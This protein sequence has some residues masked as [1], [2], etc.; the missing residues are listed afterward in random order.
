MSVI[1]HTPFPALAFR[2]YNLAGNMNGVV[3]VQGTFN[4]VDGGPMETAPDQLPL[5]MTDEFEGDPFA[6][7]M[8]AQTALVPFKPS[9]D[10]TFIG[11]TFAPGGKALRSWCCAI[12]VGSV[13]KKLRV[14]GPRDWVPLIVRRKKGLLQKEIVEEIAGWKLTEPEPVAEVPIDWTLAACD[15]AQNL[16]ANPE[17]APNGLNPLGIG[18]ISG[19]PGAKDARFAAPQIE[20]PDRPLK[21]PDQKLAPEGFGYISPWWKTR[22]Q[23]AGT[24]DD[25]WLKNR[26][27]LL[28]QDFDFRFWQSAHPDLISAK[29]FRGD[30]AYRLENLVYGHPDLRGHLPGIAMRMRLP[31]GDGFGLADFVLDG[32][33]FDLRAGKAHAVLTWRTG[34]PWP[35]GQ[36]TPE[37]AA[38]S[39][40]AEVA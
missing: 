22:L 13:S 34:F 23:Y 35:D 20:N 1:N 21:A 14:T 30:E 27:P 38:Y 15:L 33:H 40:L 26:H 37:I 29:W 17:T 4:L 16:A 39:L 25:N 6:S 18:W 36:G 12:G 9:S 19:K 5:Q 3:V 7:S 24:Y 10:V 28:P 32:V 2:Q 11:S 8:T 31:R